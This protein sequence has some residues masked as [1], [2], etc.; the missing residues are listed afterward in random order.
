MIAIEAGLVTQRESAKGIY[1]EARRHAG[2]TELA[3]TLQSHE[4]IAQNF[5]G[6]AALASAV[7]TL[8]SLPL[9]TTQRNDESI[10][11]GEL[12]NLVLLQHGTPH[13]DLP[14]WKALDQNGNIYHHALVSAA[15]GLGVA[16]VAKEKFPSVEVFTEL[17]TQG[18]ALLLSVNNSFINEH[19]LPRQ[20]KPFARL[21]PGTHILA[22][23]GYSLD[24]QMYTVFD[25]YGNAE[26]LQFSA[27]D[28]DRYSPLPPR[29][30]A[31][32]KDGQRFDAIGHIQ[33]TQIFPNEYVRQTVAAL[34]D[35]RLRK[36]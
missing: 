18:G 17:L 33:D 15:N 8:H 9:V 3:P 2:H 19:T 16:A 21:E 14:A 31:L 29:A 35:A 34:K 27:E 4:I 25:P 20:H 1:L 24:T 22:L 10:G 26:L 11:I 13:P 23:L 36:L 12:V 30:I 7:N 5:C 28:L 6:F 32:A